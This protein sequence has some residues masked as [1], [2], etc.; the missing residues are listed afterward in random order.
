VKVWKE[1]GEGVWGSVGEVKGE[2]LLRDI[3]SLSILVVSA[4]LLSS[5]LFFL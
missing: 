1:D 2:T 5:R 3:E 4:V